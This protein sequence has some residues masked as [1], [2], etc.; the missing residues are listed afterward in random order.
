MKRNSR[1][2]VPRCAHEGSCTTHSETNG[3][4]HFDGRSV[5]AGITARANTLRASSTKIGVVA[6]SRSKGLPL[7]TF[8]TSNPNIPIA[9]ANRITRRADTG[10]LG[11]KLTGKSPLQTAALHQLRPLIE[12]VASPC[13]WISADAAP[14]NRQRPSRARASGDN[15]KALRRLGFW[16]SRPNRC[17]CAREIHACDITEII[18]AR[19]SRIDA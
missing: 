13:R 5:G 14:E 1:S 4:Q 7:L 10:S 6:A 18:S 11:K 9:N 15:A 17:P 3:I 8:S 2:T 16:T 12:A 19:A